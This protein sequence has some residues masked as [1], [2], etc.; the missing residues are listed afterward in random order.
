MAQRLLTK[1]DEVVL[2]FFISSGK[3]IKYRKNKDAKCLETANFQK[4]V[5]HLLIF[6]LNKRD[7]FNLTLPIRNEP[8]F[9]C[10]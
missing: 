6:L 9:T 7:V 3:I 1:S 10:N 8:I 5:S 4:L 2:D